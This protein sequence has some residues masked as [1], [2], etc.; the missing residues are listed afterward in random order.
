LGGPIR[1]SLAKPLRLMR[2]KNTK[3]GD[4]EEVFQFSLGSGF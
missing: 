2:T 3:H 4:W 1:V